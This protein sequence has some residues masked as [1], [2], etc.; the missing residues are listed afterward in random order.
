MERELQRLS[1]FLEGKANFDSNVQFALGHSG[2]GSR[3]STR[4]KAPI[5]ASLELDTPPKETSLRKRKAFSIRQREPKA[6]GPEAQPVIAISGPAPDEVVASSTSTLSDPPSD[7]DNDKA[8][9]PP[10]PKRQKRNALAAKKSRRATPVLCLK[11]DNAE[12]RRKFSELVNGNGALNDDANSPA[13]D[14]DSGNEIESR[15]SIEMDN[16]DNESDYLP[17]PIRRSSNPARKRLTEASSAAK[18]RQ[19]RQAPRIK[20]PVIASKSS[21]LPNGP[22]LMRSL[23]LGILTPPATPNGNIAI[24]P[25]HYED[26]SPSPVTDTSILQ[27][28]SS[29]TGHKLPSLVA[30]RPRRGAPRVETT[31]PSP[32]QLFADLQQRGIVP[33][34]ESDSLVHDDSSNLQH[35][36]ISHQQLQLR[37]GLDPT[38]GRDYETKSHA[39]TQMSRRKPKPQGSPPVWAESRQV[40]CETL[41]YYRSH[42]GAGYAKDGVAYSFMFDG[43]ANGRDFMDSTVVVSRAGGGMEKD[44]ETGEMVQSRDTQETHIVRAFRNGVRFQQPV[45]LITGNKNPT[46]QFEIPYKLCVLDWFKPTHVWAEKEGDRRI[47]RYRFEILDSSKAAW[48]KGEGVVEPVQLGELAPPFS[49]KCSSCQQES[50]QVYLNGWMCINYDCQALWKFIDGTAPDS[51]RL[52]YD[53]RWLKQEV[54]WSHTSP[55][56]ATKPDP[57]ILADKSSAQFDHGMVWQATK[58]IACPNCDRCGAREHWSY[59]ECRNCHTRYNTPRSIVT[60]DLLHDWL[61]PVDT[62]YAHTKDDCHPSVKLSLAFIGNYRVHIYTIPG[63]DGFVAHMLANKTVNEEPDGPDA[64]FLAL[65]NTDIGLRRVSM[66]PKQPEESLTNQ[67]TTNFGMPY[68]FVASPDFSSFDEAPK[69]IQDSRSRLNWSARTLLSTQGQ[70]FDHEF[71]EVL[72]LGYM[73]GNKINYHDDGERGLGPTIATL[74]LGTPATMTLRMK[75]KHYKGCTD[76]LFVNMPPLPG[77]LKYEERLAAYN[78]LQKLDKK[79]PAYRRRL[80]ELPSELGLSDKTRIDPITGKS[81]RNKSEQDA[82]ISLKLCHGGVVIM[83]GAAIQEYYEHAVVPEGKLRFALTC[84]YID[85]DSLEEDARPTWTVENE[86]EPYDGFKLPEPKQ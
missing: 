36:V 55:P 40:L 58:G 4:C 62:G 2:S 7:F 84:R 74:S 10:P 41:P 1:G 27:E 81:I 28:E 49:Y 26:R 24:D 42:H 34:Q 78:S 13:S 60:P 43:Q 21:R 31:L 85:P 39:L 83:H 71:N 32:P 64:M 63:I 5:V 79:S 19:Q 75:K 17:T 22:F 47:L 82:L 8:P 48:W 38:T 30:S 11:F 73:Q 69:A 33:A 14:R 3:K 18:K 16:F 25:L 68:K 9:T 29:P 72:A 50:Q 12:S 52:V 65:Q 51:D 70:T 23:K 6:T 15:T 54:R 67:F 77:C 53:P 86:K 61:N 45:C 57:W 37:A 59:W 46:A 56:Q 20:R 66:K 80:S 44:E 76:K 35:V